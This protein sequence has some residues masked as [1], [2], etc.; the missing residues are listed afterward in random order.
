M[1]CLQCDLVIWAFTK[2]RVDMYVEG[3]IGS[4]YWGEGR[5][6]HAR[7][8]GTVDAVGDDGDEVAGGEGRVMLTFAYESRL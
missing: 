2:A 5:W 1:R 6:V 3:L 7:G 4:G 8:Y